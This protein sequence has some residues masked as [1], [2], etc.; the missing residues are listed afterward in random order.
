ML[1]TRFSQ[2]CVDYRWT[3]EKY[4]QIYRSSTN[5][6]PF[7]EPIQMTKGGKKAILKTLTQ[8]TSVTILLLFNFSTTSHW[9]WKDL[10]ELSLVQKLMMHP[11][12]NRDNWRSGF[13]FFG[14][15]TLVICINSLPFTTSTHF[16]I[17]CKLQPH[18][19]KVLIFF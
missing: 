17:G 9:H 3:N 6:Y 13:H 8:I 2:L 16:K 1:F 14:L 10:W 12:S 19:I 7:R 4:K 5:S 18:L 11:S 15:L